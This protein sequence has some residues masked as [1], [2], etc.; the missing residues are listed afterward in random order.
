MITFSWPMRMLILLGPAAREPLH[1]LLDDNE[2][3]NEVVLVLGAIGDETTV[4]L[5]IDRYPRQLDPEKQ[6][7]KMVCFSF[8]LAHRTGEVLDRDRTGTTICAD[9]A[10]K[11]RTWW[12]KEGRT[13]RVPAEK[14]DSSAMPMYPVLTKEWAMQMRSE[15][16]KGP[17]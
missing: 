5:L 4:P 14:P 9:N 6:R 1:R 7:F 3:Q 10:G 8:A 13:F 15:F 16:A 11:W 17:D 12:T 2:I